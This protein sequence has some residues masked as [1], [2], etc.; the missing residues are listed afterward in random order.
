MFRLKS[1]ESVVE[2]VT[3]F[4]TLSLTTVENVVL[5]GTPLPDMK[6]GTFLKC[7]FTGATMPDNLE[8]ALFVD[9]RLS[10]LNFLKANLFKARFIRCDFSESHFRDCDLSAAQ[11]EDCQLTTAEFSNCDLEASEGV[12]DGLAA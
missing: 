7:D 1:I 10:R 11:F 9:C 12:N 8:S 3:D 4:Q 2:H 6:D 5:S